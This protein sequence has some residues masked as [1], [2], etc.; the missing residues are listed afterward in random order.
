[1]IKEKKIL[2]QINVNEIVLIKESNG[3]IKCI[4]C[5]SSTIANCG[6]SFNAANLATSENQTYC[7]VRYWIYFEK[8]ICESI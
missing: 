4:V 6:Q 8:N 5:T 3:Y 2:S 1:M 7:Q